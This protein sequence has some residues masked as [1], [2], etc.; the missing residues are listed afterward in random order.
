MYRFN[1][2]QFS[3]GDIWSMRNNLRAYVTTDITSEFQSQG[4]EKQIIARHFDHSGATIQSCCQVGVKHGQTQYQEIS[5][6]S[7]EMTELVEK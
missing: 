2:D 4:F 5:C 6:R 7:K 3:P 1:F